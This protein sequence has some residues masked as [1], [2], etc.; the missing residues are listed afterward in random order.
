MAGAANIDELEHPRAISAAGWR[1]IARR[2]RNPARR[3]QASIIAGGVAFFAFLAMFPAL[4]ALVSGYGLLADPEDV[5]RQVDVLASGFPEEVQTAIYDQMQRLVARSPGTLSLEAAVSILGA[6]WAATKGT[7]AL[8]TG[9]SLA[10]GQRETRGFIRLKVTAFLFT[11]GAIVFGAFAVGAVIAFPIVL[12]HLHLSPPSQRLMRWLRWPAVAGV[13][14]FGLSVAYHYG[15]ARAPGR[16]R[17]VT[18]GSVA[19]TAMWLAGSALFSW[20]VS[21]FA[22]G[23]KLDG[24]LGVIITL[25]TWFLLSA[26]VVILGAELNAEI[27]RQKTPG[28]D[29]RPD[30]GT[31]ELE[32]PGS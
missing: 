31:G 23:G 15:P 20:S 19:A 10:F 26:Y 28:L 17:L 21:T 8:I 22:G 29:D 18:A 7:K 2:M 27:A 4:V 12:S 3:H 14:L 1:E 16:W 9:L 6:V 25:L 32:L 24:S 30:R 5:R 13:V 11:M